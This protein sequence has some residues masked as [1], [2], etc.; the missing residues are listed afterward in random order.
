MQTILGAGG[1]VG[2]E[3]AKALKAYDPQL[4]LL[5]RH[6][7]KIND[8][9]ELM[10]GDLMK[11]EDVDKAVEGAAVVYLVAGLPYQLK[12]WQEQ[13]PR[14]MQNT[15]EACER[16]R[17]KLVFFDNIYMYDKTSIGNITEASPVNPPS[18]KGRVRAAIAEMVARAIQNKT[19]E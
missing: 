18:K 3:L 16:H 12:T 9:D 5:A 19:L 10:S 11:Q 17:A 15:I 13:W 8:S 7:K 2:I 1:A 14:I 6:P 4:R